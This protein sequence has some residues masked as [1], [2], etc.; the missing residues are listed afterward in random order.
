MAKSIRPP[1]MSSLERLMEEVMGHAVEDREARSCRRSVGRDAG[2]SC[3]DWQ[4]G[5][6]GGLMV[7][8]D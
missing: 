5:G 4:A 2:E 7:K 1:K 3:H 8:E 6:G